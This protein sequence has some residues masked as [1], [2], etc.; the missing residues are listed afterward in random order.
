MNLKVSTVSL[1]KFE[2]VGMY[3][4]GFIKHYDYYLNEFY[5]FDF[6]L[7]LISE[8]RIFW[9]PIWLHVTLWHFIT[10]FDSGQGAGL[11]FDFDKQWI[12]GECLQLHDQTWY[13][14]AM[15]S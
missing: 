8:G 5:L 15:L 13:L 11:E 4:L 14:K 10:D 6:S 7:I 12:I 1:L 9:N 2:K 3:F